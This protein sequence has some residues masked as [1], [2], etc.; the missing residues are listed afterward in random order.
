MAADLGRLIESPYTALS[1]TIV[2]AA[3]ALSGKFSV[4]ATQIL[5]VAGWAMAVI[6][7]RGQ[8]LPVMIGTSLCIGGVLVL[9]GYWFRPDAVPSNFGRLMPEAKATLIFS[10]TQNETSPKF[11]IGQSG[12]V[13]VGQSNQIGGL[14]FPALEETQFKIEKI[15]DQIKVSTQIAD[16][17]GALVVEIVRNEW[18][19]GPPP[20]TWDRNY[21]SDSLEV[22][23]PKG[24][25]VLQVRVL[26]DLIQI[27]GIWPLG[28]KWKASGARRVVIRQ[29]P[30]S[31]ND[32]QYIFLPKEPKE[33][34]MIPRMFEYPSDLHLGELA[35]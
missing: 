24:H 31:P 32:A 33:W 14:L 19:V 22:L 28:E 27:Q 17:S 25:V 18:R 6:G 23:D 4:T 1:L 35:K 26:K 16:D 3:L 8:A 9:L 15:D 21:N 5:L 20:L 34:P 13:F 2:L 12:V 11:Q 7:L 29:D 30:Q 10:P